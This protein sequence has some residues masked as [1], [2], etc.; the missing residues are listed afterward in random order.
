M[1]M[2]SRRHVAKQFEQTREDLMERAQEMA[3]KAGASRE[4]LARRAE[5]IRE[6]FAENVTQEAVTNFVGWTMVS[7]GIAWGVTDWTRGRRAWTSYLLPGLLVALGAAAM[8]GGRVWQHRAALIDEAELRV[9]DDLRTLDPFAR[10]RVLRDMSEET[11]PL[12]RR[13]AR[14][15]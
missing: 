2:M 10:L 9:R 14:H 4:D 5:I 15:N 12:I 13:L 1:H 3:E 8:S 7:A 11:A 6:R